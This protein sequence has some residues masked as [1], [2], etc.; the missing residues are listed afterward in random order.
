[1]LVER[2]QAISNALW[3]GRST[4]VVKHVLP[5]AFSLLNDTK[6]EGKA[7]AQVG[8]GVICTR[9]CV[10]VCARSRAR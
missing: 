5:A 8:E 7:A 4:L 2:L 6:G 10:C 9:V 3:P 1:M